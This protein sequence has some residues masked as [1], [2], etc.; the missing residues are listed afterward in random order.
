MTVALWLPVIVLFVV[1]VVDVGNWFVHKRHLQM[2]ADAGALAGGGTFTFPCSD[3]PIVGETRKYAGD[4]GAGAPYNLQIPPTDQ[5]NVH[6]LVNS[7]SYW[8]EGGTDYSDGGPPCAARMV[9]VKITEANLPWFFGL[10]VVPAINAH[11]R[12]VIQ[13]LHRAR[14]ALPVAVPDIDPRVAR[15]YFVDE[16]SGA[17]IGSAPL[18]KVGT[19]GGLAIWDN[20]GAPLS[21]P[22]S[23]SRIGVRIA[24]GGASSTTCG[25]YLVECYDLESS[26]GI[27]YVRGWSSSGSA[28]PPNPPIARDVSLFTGSC[29]DAYFNSQASSCTIGVSASVDFGGVPLGPTTIVRA[30]VGGVEKQLVY[31][32]ASGRFV[33]SAS[34]ASFFTVNPNAGPLSVEL[35]WEVTQTGVT[36]QGN[37]CK[38]NGNKCK[39]TFGIV[40][41]TFSAATAWS[42]PVEVAQIWEG[43]VGGA[44]SF[45]TGTTH[46]LVVRIGIQGNL[47][48]AQSVSDPVV[49]LRVTGSQNQSVDCD[50]DLPNL[51]DEI[52]YGC[53][54][55]YAIND[56]VSCPYT[57][58]PALW[59]SP[60]PWNCV[61]IQTGG[62]VGQVEQGLRDRILG[63][64]SSCTSPNNWSSFPNIPPDDPRI[65]PIFITPFG[66]FTGTGNEVVP[67][68]NFA[69]FYV[70]GWFSSPCSGDDP[71][72]DKGYI[73]GHFIKYIYKLNDGGGS[74]DLCDFSAFGS[75]IAVLTD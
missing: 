7:Q 21:V 74:G 58:H 63:G 73:V 48:V 27:V 38:P 56:A 68:T 62:A 66:T 42:G 18:A 32:S 25:G 45:E 29:P 31:D 72:P 3:S 39:G 71:V 49:L 20:A 59:A 52:R 61:A 15:A 69:T 57:T 2:Q 30:V 75:C 6:V 1:F 19:S 43:G 36:I 67:V 41:R 16:S 13:A 55:E 10:D 5:S 54:P 60:R 8:N 24:L 37:D 28:V 46:D 65:V 23:S 53:A 4:Q 44:N 34:N 64:A 14:G 26:N 40:Q 50:P 47:E 11:A 22:I 51:R 17:V 35:K 33:S 12:V 9:D 70:T